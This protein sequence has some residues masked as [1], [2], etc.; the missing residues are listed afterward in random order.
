MKERDIRRT[1]IS[2]IVSLFGSLQA[3][4]LLTRSFPECS[5]IKH[6]ND[7]M[8]VVL[9]NVIDNRDLFV[10]KL[11]TI[12][13]LHSKVLEEEDN[14]ITKINRI[15]GLMNVNY[16]E[17]RKIITAKYVPSVL[18]SDEEKYL[19]IDKNFIPD[20]FYNDLIEQIN[21][22]FLDCCYSASTILLR[23]LFENLLID[24]LRKKY[25]TKECKYLY[26]NE[27]RKHFLNFAKLIENFKE[28][29]ND[30]II[31]S[32]KIEKNFIKFLEE[33]IK[34]PGNESA[35]TIEEIIE[36]KDLRLKQN[37]INSYLRLLFSILQKI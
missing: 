32:K 3:N 33:K 2:S 11:E 21:V 10:L 9:D 7:C 36:E 1:I 34:F 27:R 20:S 26:W 19:D 22:T 13:N 5:D 29:L 8:R 4:S 14:L 37:E 30:F 23:K 24:I 17:N 25:G 18:L 6:K 16:E 28:K 31:Y 35:H 12:I 15:L